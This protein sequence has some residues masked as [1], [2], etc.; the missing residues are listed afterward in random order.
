MSYYISDTGALY[1]NPALVKGFYWY[2]APPD[3]GPG[4]IQWLKDFVKLVKVRKT[5]SVADTSIGG[6]VVNAHTWALFEVG[7]VPVP[8]LDARKFG[9]PNTAT[10]DTDVSVVSSGAEGSKNPLDTL[11]DAVSDLPKT[12]AGA[13]GVATPVVVV[14]A[15]GLSLYFFRKELFE[16]GKAKLRHFR[17]ASGRRA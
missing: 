15:I 11:G 6:D 7:E 4:F 5:A 2:D 13:I 14:G 12:L 9:F 10:E 8:W 17:R 1:R 16:H 3:K